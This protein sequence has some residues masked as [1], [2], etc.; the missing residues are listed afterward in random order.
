MI[1]YHGS[2]T[3]RIKILEPRK[4]PRTKKTGVFLS[5]V[6]E[7]TEPAA[8]LRHRHKADIQ[9]WTENGKFVRGE[10]TASPDL[11]LPRGTIYAVD[12]R[13]DDTNLVKLPDGVYLYLTYVWVVDSQPITLEEVKSRWSIV[14][15]LQEVGNG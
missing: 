6:R 11:L 5:D 13:S 15:P 4:D 1:L 8:I 2:Q 7:V 3:S 10:I 12:V 9:V 14:N